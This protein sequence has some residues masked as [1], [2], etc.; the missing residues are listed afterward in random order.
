[1]APV[2]YGNNGTMQPAAHEIAHVSDTARLTAACRAMETDRP[3]G[4]VRDP[5]GVHLLGR[6]LAGESACPTL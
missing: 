6:Q 1:M 4:L 2:A 5:S 3:D